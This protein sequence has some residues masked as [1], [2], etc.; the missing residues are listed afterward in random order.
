M[1]LT[2]ESY[3]FTPG[4][5]LPKAAALSL[6]RSNLFSDV[7]F[8]FGGE[9]DRADLV[10]SGAIKSTNYQGNMWSY[11]LSLFGSIPWFFGLPVG[12]SQN[13]LMIEF[14][15]KKKNRIIWEYSFAR[16]HR[17]WQW[18]YY[19]MGHD[20]LGY[21]ELMQEAMNEAILDLAARLRDNPASLQ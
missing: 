12:N 3:D 21:S 14:Q 9:K 17:I 10:L 13:T 8:T 15:L 18:L 20:V 19:R 2:I 11:G 16:S 6:R 4:E 5:D 1:F 7:F